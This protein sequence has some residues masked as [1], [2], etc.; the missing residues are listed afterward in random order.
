M[1]RKAKTAAL[2]SMLF[3][4]GLAAAYLD[5]AYLTHPWHQAGVHDPV[6]TWLST[7]GLDDLGG[8]WSIVWI[9]LPAWMISLSVGL[10][11]GLFVRADLLV[12]FGL[13]FCAGFV[14]LPQIAS[15]AGRNTWTL[16]ATAIV[17]SFLWN[18]VSL[19]IAVLGGTLSMRR[20]IVR[21]KIGTLTF[22]ATRLLVVTAGFA[23]TFFAITNSRL[24]ALPCLLL[25]FLT[26]LAYTALRR[27]LDTEGAVG[28]TTRV[29]RTTR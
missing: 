7:V 2:A 28:P 20:R 18:A 12:L 16:G 22:S 8:C 3:I 23:A 10:L 15:V 26:L 24:V 11:L 14:L 6:S 5:A 19:P 25:G 9:Y 1:V 27:R 29:C 17:G 4:A 13:S 21:A